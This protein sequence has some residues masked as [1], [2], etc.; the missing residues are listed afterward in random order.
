MPKITAA[1]VTE[2]RVAQRRALIAAAEAIIGELG[3]AAVTPRSVGER[4]GLARSS[5]YE[6][7]PSK[8]DLLA[9]LAIQ[10]F[11]EWETEVRA[12]VSAAT[13]GRARLHAYV[14]ATMRM[15]GDGKHAL[16]TRM[17]RTEL[18]PKGFE[19]IMAMHDSLA[20]PLRDV[21]DDLRIPDA[22]AQAALVQ[23]LLNAGVQLIEHG[24]PADAVT[25]RITTILDTGLHA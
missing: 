22:P 6:Y 9:A 17:R 3:V 15:T 5:F 24:A 11:D 1:T 10:A 2:H 8:D 12:A 16:A 21:L 19:A 13:P 4:A 23:G 14:E 18:S 25:A 20:A 7:F